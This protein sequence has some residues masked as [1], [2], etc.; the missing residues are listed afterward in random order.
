VLAIELD[1]G[2][3]LWECRGLRGMVDD[4]YRALRGTL[5]RLSL[6]AGDGKV[7]VRDADAVVAI[8]AR[9]GKRSWS[10]TVEAPALAPPSVPRPWD[11]STPF[12]D[13]LY[14]EGVVYCWQ[15]TALRGM[16]APIELRA[17][18]AAD[19]SLLWKKDCGAGGFRSTHHHRCYR[20]KA[21][22]NYIIFSRNGLELVDLRTGRPNINRWV[23]GICAYGIMPANGLIYVPPQQCACFPNAHLPG[24][25]AYGGARS[26]GARRLVADEHRLEQGPA[27]GAKSI[28]PELTAED[29][30][31]FR[32]DPLRSA[33][34]P[35]VLP[36]ELSPAWRFDLNEPVTA[37]TVGWGKVFLVGLR[38]H[39]VIALDTQTGRLV[40]SFRADNRVDTPPTLYQGKVYFGTAGGY[41]CYRSW[42]AAT[43]SPGGLSTAAW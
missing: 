14:S 15:V 34:T 43:S 11:V 3:V 6:T 30:P 35:V 9:S 7:F 37:P 38:T 13:L 16:P 2:K 32:H 8:D 23:R 24:L 17:L 36:R 26:Y 33:A 40:W 5:T 20:N 18:A 1:S 27:C 29:W 12:S 42:F 41:A 39:R 4:K 31:I 25:I 28:A 21:T 22:E 10:A 19:G